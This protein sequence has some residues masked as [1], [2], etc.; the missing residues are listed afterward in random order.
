MQNKLYRVTNANVNALMAELEQFFR[1]QGHQVQV[2]PVNGSQIL[3]A[4]KETTL[5]TI[6]GQSSALTIKVTAE[7]TG[8]RVEIGSSKWIDKA[9]IGVIGYV[10]MPLLAIIPIIGAYNQY[11]LSEDAWHIVDAFM[12]R[13]E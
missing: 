13:Q 10:I 7:Q 1:M 12:A 9:A 8:T 2:I 5:S 3:Q 6:T 4:L 11:K